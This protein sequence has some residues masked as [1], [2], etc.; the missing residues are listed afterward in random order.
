MW[1]KAVHPSFPFLSATRRV[2]IL[3]DM[4]LTSRR[5]V[6]SLALASEVK[7]LALDVSIK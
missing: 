4:A 7:S 5:L 2:G 3:E 6:V 1:Q